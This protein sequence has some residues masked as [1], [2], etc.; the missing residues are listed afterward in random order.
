VVRRN[1]QIDELLAL[2]A[3]YVINS[4]AENI[5]E[6]VKEITKV[7]YSYY[8]YIIHFLSIYFVMHILYSHF[9]TVIC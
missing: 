7:Q 2:G 1:D 6:R 8:S 4:E 5:P 3:D 9:C